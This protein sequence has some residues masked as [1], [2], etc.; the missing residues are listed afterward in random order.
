MD[1]LA[2][3]FSLTEAN[4][5]THAYLAVVSQRSGIRALSIK[6]LVSDRYE[7]REP[8]IAADA[9]VLVDPRRFDE[10]CELLKAGGWRPRLERDVP[11]LMEQ[12]SVTL[13]REGWPNDIDVHVYFPGFFAD[14][15]ATFD[16]LWET[17]ASMEVAHVDIAV[18]SRAGAAVIGALHSLRY[19]RSI[20][21]SSELERIVDIVANDFDDADREDFLGIA[22]AGAAQW[23]LGEVLERIG[24]PVVVDIDA[25][26]QR[27]W[28]TNR[29]TIEDGAAVS[30]LAAFRGAP[31]H[32]K[33]ALLFRAL[34]ISRDDI[35]RN[36][37]LHR[38]TV[39]EAWA[40]RRLRWR[41]GAIALWHYLRGT[42]GRS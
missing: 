16:R 21:H 41:R 32:R 35:P 14:R 40:H 27:L 9:D 5:L 3:N 19:T 6:G 29:K 11:S 13:I 12:H 23:V 4:E 24:V 7:L 20:R 17:R 1:T 36:D 42:F 37:P 10:F 15:A 38:P 18:P 31:L 33:P 28:A 25:H 8:R 34:W 30:W 2:S 39:A 26:Q 22:R